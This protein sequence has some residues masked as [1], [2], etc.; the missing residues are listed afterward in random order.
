MAVISLTCIRFD[1]TEHQTILS[2][3]GTDH[4]NGRLATVAVVKS[5]VRSCRQWRSAHHRYALT[6]P[7]SSGQRRFE[8]VRLNGG[9]WLWWSNNRKK[10]KF[11]E[12]RKMA[13]MEWNILKQL[14][15]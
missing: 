1:L 5:C 10:W 14:M 8:I 3:K 2:G 11:N 7:A 13:Q 6:L 9:S 15:E 12:G 4:M